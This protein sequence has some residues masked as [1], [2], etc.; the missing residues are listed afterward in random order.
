MGRIDYDDRQ[1]RVFSRARAVL[2]DNRRLW[3]GIF[4][5]W[6]G[7]AATVLDVG[8]GVGHYSTV[9]ADALDGA[10][11]IGV[12]PSDNM[13]G[14]AEAEHAHERV[15]YIA[16][17]AEAMP[18]DDE[19]A[20]SALVSNV[21]HHIEDRAAAAAELHRVLSAG[22]PL[23]IR[24]SL[25]DALRGNPHWD[26]FPGALEIAEAASPSVDEVV[27]LFTSSGF[28]CLA[29]ETVKQ[30][31]APSLEA[32][33]ERISH[34]AISTLELLDDEVFEQGLADLRA[35]AA[36]ETEPRPVMELMDLVVLRRS[37]G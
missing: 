12:E 28:E 37:A 11:V 4:R 18:L 3:T 35:A 5:H 8:A 24:G 21:I 17:R 19:S 9:L 20:D 16:G 26:C 10:H 13:R 2:P 7:R 23:L 25:R 15:T 36:A 14:V 6:M 33:A 29:L 34:R 30:P 27:E 32:F 22:A 1:Y 31:T